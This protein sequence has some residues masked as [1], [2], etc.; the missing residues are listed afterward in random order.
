VFLRIEDHSTDISVAGNNFSRIKK[1]VYIDATIDV[2]ELKISPNLTGKNTLFEILQ[3]NIE[4]DSIGYVRIYYPDAEVHY[5]LDGSEPTRSSEK[6]SK[7]FLQ[8]APAV[9][10][11][12]AFK[13]NDESGTA[14][15]SFERLQVLKPVIVPADRFFFKKINVTLTSPTPGAEILYTI[16][17]SSPEKTGK[18]YERPV[19]ITGRTTLRTVAVKD[20]YV[21][22]DEASSRYEPVEIKSGVHYNYYEGRWEYLPGFI[23]MKPIRQGTL[24]KFT[25]DG[26][27]DKKMYFG[28]VMDALLD[29][30]K[31]GEYTFYASSNDGSILL[32]DNEVVVNNDGAH[33]TVE[34]QGKVFL[35]KGKH[36]IEVRYFQAGGGKSLKV[37]WEGPGFG[38]Q[39]IPADALKN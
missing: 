13:E 25:I 12:K 24:E 35:K 37:S 1:P 5:T 18:N 6:Y 26:V 27:T 7:P 22:S 23:G 10:K 28:L 36:L 39:E 30:K 11:A 33:G 14:E 8:V 21:A 4:R 34:K 15:V 17:G 29:V 9:V 20:G 2:K 31:T 19:E 3:P 32:I 16:D 38:K